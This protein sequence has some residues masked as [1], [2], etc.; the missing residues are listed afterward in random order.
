MISPILRPSRETFTVDRHRI[1]IG[2]KS[3]RNRIEIR[4]TSQP[5]TKAHIQGKTMNK[6]MATKLSSLPCFETFWVT[7]GL[8]FCSRFRLICGGGVTHAFLTCF[9]VGQLLKAKECKP[10]SDFAI[11]RRNSR[12]FLQRERHLVSFQFAERNHKR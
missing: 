10:E 5:F 8:D 4:S 6:H 9:P 3:D 7:F 1:E 2:S 11:A 12:H